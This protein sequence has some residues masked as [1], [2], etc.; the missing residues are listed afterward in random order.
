MSV[1]N[2]KREGIATLVLERAEKANALSAEMVAD[3]HAAVVAAVSDPEVHT[4]VLRGAGDHF[5][6]GFDLSTLESE[7][8]ASLAERFI[9]L[10]KLL[11]AVWHAPVRT[12][13]V[14]QGRAWGAGADLFASCDVRVAGED[15]SFRFPGSAFG[16]VLGTAR[17]VELIGWDNARPFVTEGF[18]CDAQ[19]AWDAGLATQVGID[20]WL[21]E[22]PRNV[23]VDR[24]TFAAIR[25][26]TRA[27]RRAADLATLEASARRPG[28]KARIEAYRARLRSSRG[29]Q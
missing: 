16:I 8:D 26:A 12:I 10:E 14:A 7:T 25:T 17:L 3:L 5:C 4:V 24:E 1:R 15:A 6:T 22:T 21:E 9:A 29:T 18:S 20:E 13:A 28:L 23:V 2:V 11:Q 19:T 27:D